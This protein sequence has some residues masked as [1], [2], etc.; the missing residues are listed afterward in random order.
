MCCCAIGCQHSTLNRLFGS[1]F[2]LCF[3]GMTS[4]LANHRCTLSYVFSTIFLFLTFL[5]IHMYFI[6][7]K[8]YDQQFTLTTK[9][10][11]HIIFNDW[12][13][14]KGPMPI[15]RTFIKLI[16]SIIDRS[17]DN[18]RTTSFS[19]SNKTMSRNASDTGHSSCSKLVSR[20][21]SPLTTCRN[22]PAFLWYHDCR[23]RMIISRTVFTWAARLPQLSPHVCLTHRCGTVPVGTATTTSDALVVGF[24]ADGCLCR[25]WRFIAN[26][27]DCNTLHTPHVKT[28]NSILQ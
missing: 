8:T 22:G 23:R 3:P 27:D 5:N 14:N 10:S 15:V 24:A 21:Q 17:D 19:A 16:S 7:L 26:F 9:K 6:I 25:W 13:L 11:L 1:W 18:D 12:S 4:S 2:W 28:F 20:V